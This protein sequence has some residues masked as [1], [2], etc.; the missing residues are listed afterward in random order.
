MI[1]A[2][3]LRADKLLYIAI[4]PANAYQFEK[5]QLPSSIKFGHSEGSQNLMWGY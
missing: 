1:S 2:R 5:F 4:V 3:H